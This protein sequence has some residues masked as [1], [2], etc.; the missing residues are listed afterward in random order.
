MS[1]RA[2]YFGTFHS[3]YPGNALLIKGLRQNGVEVSVCHV[4][5]GEKSR[6]KYHEYGSFVSKVRLAILYLGA[7]VKLCLGYLKAGPHDTIIYGYLGQLD[8]PLVYLISRLRRKPV[9]FNPMFSLYDTVVLD[10]QLFRD[11]SVAA[12][13]LSFLDRFAFRISTIVFLDTR[14]HIRIW[15]D[16]LG[17]DPERIRQLN[18]GADDSIF[19]P[20]ETAAHEA[21]FRVIFYGTFMPTQGVPIIVEAA[22]ILEREGVRFEIIGF[23]QDSEK[24]RNLADHIRPTNVTFVEWVNF[25]ELPERIARAHVALGMFGT[26]DKMKRCLPNKIVQ[27]LAMGCPVITGESPSVREYCRH[28]KDIFLCEPGDPVKLA[29]AIRTLRD[30]PELRATIAEGALELYRDQFTPLA[31]G[32]KAR[33]FMEEII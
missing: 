30:D 1:L 33:G 32:A 3:T 4:P 8:A 28:G 17:C 19:F 11:G 22:K 31:V 13:I 16:R 20:R 23:G 2:L 5:L 26:S 18:F 21:P 9:V 14:E 27:C 15:T 6:S 24:V 29:E 25:E 7:Y 10:R 12:R